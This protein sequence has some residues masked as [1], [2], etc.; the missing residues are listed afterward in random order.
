MT[1]VGAHALGVSLDAYRRNRSWRFHGML[2]L[3]DTVDGSVYDALC[4]RLRG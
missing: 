4:R 3:L 2:A 1:L